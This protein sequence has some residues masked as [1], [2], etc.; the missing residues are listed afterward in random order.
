MPN[1]CE[2]Q[3][4]YLQHQPSDC[5]SPFERTKELSFPINYGQNKEK[6]KPVNTKRKFNNQLLSPRLEHKQP[7][8]SLCRAYYWGGE[9]EREEATC[10]QI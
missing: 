10:S 3:H 6:E 5:R 9:R 8:C 1:F 7:M 4:V 2:E